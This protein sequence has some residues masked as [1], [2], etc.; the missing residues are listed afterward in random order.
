M[1]NFRAYRGIGQLSPF[2]DSMIQFHLMNSGLAFERIDYVRWLG[3]NPFSIP[4]NLVAA[5]LGVRVARVV[6][7]LGACCLWLVVALAIVL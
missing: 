3:R 4:S 2:C 1:S 6:L 5:S 7:E